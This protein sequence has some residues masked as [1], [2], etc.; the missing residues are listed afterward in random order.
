VEEI[1]HDRT[2]WNTSDIPRYQA[3]HYQVCPGQYWIDH[4]CND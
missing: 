1:R 4:W 3:G 2:Y